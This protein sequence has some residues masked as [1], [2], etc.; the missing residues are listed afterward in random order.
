VV[1]SEFIV[2][3]TILEPKD[4]MEEGQ[5]NFKDETRRSNDLDLPFHRNELLNEKKRV[6]GVIMTCLLNLSMHHVD[7]TLL[8][9][10]LA[11]LTLEHVNTLN[12]R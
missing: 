5:Q 1:H 8:A 7:P 11:A 6:R 4:K 12:K 10:E 9:E 2:Y 3:M